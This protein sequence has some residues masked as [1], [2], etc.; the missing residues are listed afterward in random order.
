MSNKRTH[1]RCYMPRGPPGPTPLSPCHTRSGR[2]RTHHLTDPGPLLDVSGHSP[3]HSRNMHDEQSEQRPPGPQQ[4]TDP[5]ASFGAQ[6]LSA[7]ISQIVVDG[8]LQ[9]ITNGLA[10]ILPKVIDR[11]SQGLA[12]SHQFDLAAGF[13]PV[14]QPSF[15]PN[16][17]P[18]TIPAALP[19][20]KRVLSPTWLQEARRAA[21][22]DPRPSFQGSASRSPHPPSLDESSRQSLFKPM[23]FFDGHPRTC[24]DDQRRR[25]FTN[26]ATCSRTFPCDSSSVA[27]TSTSSLAS[28]KHFTSRCAGLGSRQSPQPGSRGTDHLRSPA[29]SRTQFPD[30]RPSHLPPEL[31]LLQR[32]MAELAPTVPPSRQR[33][34]ASEP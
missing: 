23:P 32:A 20:R 4:P 14:H 31:D 25:T 18:R 19:S 7:T 29:R 22:L 6:Q 1:S 27:T 13:L 34:P 30:S 9:G 17:A 12:S 21:Y 11:I 24:Q 8:I 15:T 5:T 2:I 3:V 16:T 28:I 33:Q 26:Y 10:I